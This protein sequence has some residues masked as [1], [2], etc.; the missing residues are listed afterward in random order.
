MVII[1]M[2]GEWRKRTH[3]WSW[4]DKIP[5]CYAS[6]A[7]N[8]YASAAVSVA[9]ACP[10]KLFCGQDRPTLCPEHSW[11]PSESSGVPLYSTS[12]FPVKKFRVPRTQN[13]IWGSIQ[14]GR[15]QGGGTLRWAA[16][17]SYVPWPV[18]EPRSKMQ[19]PLVA[20]TPR[21]FTMLLLENFQISALQLCMA[22][23]ILVGVNILW[24]LWIPF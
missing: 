24:H 11:K 19:R 12:S 15:L 2:N 8:C 20:G 18:T 22:D 5:R 23:L 6:G 7:E 1:M 21:K 9:S 13:I 10:S 17:C 14:Q 16:C 3:C 4:E